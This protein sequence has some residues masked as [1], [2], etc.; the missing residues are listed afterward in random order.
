MVYPVGEN[1][2]AEKV[3]ME[4]VHMSLYQTTR[5]PPIFL[6]GPQVRIQ[7]LAHTAEEIV[8]M[9]RGWMVGNKFP[10]RSEFA[11]FSFPAGWWE[12]LKQAHAPKWFLARWPVKM[13]VHRFE[14]AHYRY[15]VCPHWAEDFSRD[16]MPHVSFL[17]DRPELYRKEH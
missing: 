10:D 7:Q 2:V 12:A 5:E 6:H 8:V 9:L 14:C 16:K 11:E 4:Q 13:S 15:H 1:V 3:L 17:A